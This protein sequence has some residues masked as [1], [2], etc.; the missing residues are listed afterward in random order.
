MAGPR[1]S[2]EAALK[3]LAALLAVAT[4]A[5]CA[6]GRWEW[7]RPDGPGEP[8]ELRVDVAECEERARQTEDRRRYR[9]VEG[10]RPYGGWGNFDFEFCMN[11]RDW[12]LRYLRAGE[13]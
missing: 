10:A 2:E 4:A 12:Q 5:G 9:S 13:P 11:Q 7:Q 3:A 1:T 8:E 6:T